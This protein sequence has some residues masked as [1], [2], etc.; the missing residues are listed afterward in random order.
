MSHEGCDL[1]TMRSWM[2]TKRSPSQGRGSERAREYRE[3]KDQAPSDDA[4]DADLRKG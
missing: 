2:A 3:Q 4:I 1:S